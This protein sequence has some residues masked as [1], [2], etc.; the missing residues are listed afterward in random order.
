[1]KRTDTVIINGQNKLSGTVSIQGS[2][3]A[4]LP[5]L[6][7]TTLFNGNVKLYNVPDL[8]DI[9]SM[10]A[11]LNYL[12]ATSSFESGVIE[13]DCSNLTSKEIPDELSTKLR[14]SSLLLGPLLSRFKK[15]QVAMPGGCKIGTRP[16]DIHYKGFE[17]MGADVKLENGLITVE[18]NTY[19][20]EF[21]LDMPSVGATENLISASVYNDSSVT[22]RN[23]A[24]EPEIMDLVKFLQAG[25]ADISFNE[26]H[27]SVT[28]KPVAQLQSV[29]YTIQPDRIEAGTFLFAAFATKGSVELVGVIPEHLAAPLEKLRDM[30][31][32]IEINNDRIK[33]SYDGRIDGT[34]VVTDVYPGFPTDLQSPIG[35]LMTQATS[36]STLIENVYENR[37]TYI[38]ELL[39][40]NAKVS[41][42][43]RT[44]V[45]E[46]S[47]LSGCRVV[48]P[49]LRGAA[50]MIIA[51]LVS[52]GV[53]YVSELR[54]L[55]RGYESFV[56][57]LRHLG[58]DICYE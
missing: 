9:H 12:G 54:H 15:A 47:K 37:F 43:G 17:K 39:R 44:A 34:K 10:L 49:D 57:K 46:K 51:G 30:G 23:Y 24:K 1:M 13:L 8:A 50:A 25:G 26:D 3:N 52:D 20:G 16:M 28:I 5:I 53:T 35:I 14:A 55:Y 7:A 58:A 29:E 36:P 18:S 4:A 19:E 32:L 11:I 22:L 6:A 31:A 27:S 21:T 42:D 56:E 41:V 48:S 45:F 40:M 33:L 2:K 38:H